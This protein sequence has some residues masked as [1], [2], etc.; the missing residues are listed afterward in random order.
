MLFPF[1]KLNITIVKRNISFLVWVNKNIK[2]VM[3]D[4]SGYVHFAE[5]SLTRCPEGCLLCLQFTAFICTSG[6]SYRYI[7]ST[8]CH[9]IY[10]GKTTRCAGRQ[11][12]K[13]FLTRQLGDWDS[14]HITDGT[15]SAVHKST[16]GGLNFQMP[17]HLH[18]PALSLPT[19]T[20]QGEE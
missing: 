12:V 7:S 14:V 16:A 18:H 1:L 6:R 3:M 19:S 20:T 15:C 4:L 5:Y 10:F 11:G 13:Y 2:R 8:S 9:C 17:T